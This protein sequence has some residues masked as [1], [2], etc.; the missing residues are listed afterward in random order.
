MKSK[1]S[2]ESR[3]CNCNG[4]CL[5]SDVVYR[6]K[7]INSEETKYYRG[8]TDGYGKDDSTTLK[9]FWPI[10]ST[11]VALFFLSTIGKSLTTGNHLIPSHVLVKFKRYKGVSKFCNFCLV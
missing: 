1:Y 10:K 7:V 2:K 5:V 6:A 9:E 4:V 8:D 11:N 3:R